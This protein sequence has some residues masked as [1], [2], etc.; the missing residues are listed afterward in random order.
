M[1]TPSLLSLVMRMRRSTLLRTSS[2][3]STISL[4]TSYGLAPRQVV[5]TVMRGR[6]NGG[7]ELDGHMIIEAN[8]AKQG[9][10]EDAHRDAD[11]LADRKLDEAH[12]AFPLE[13]LGSSKRTTDGCRPQLGGW[14]LRHLARPAYTRDRTPGKPRGIAMARHR[15]FF[16]CGLLCVLLLL[17]STA[18][19]AQQGR[20]ALV[21]V[22]P[23]LQKAIATPVTFVGTVEPRRRSLVASEL[24]G[25]RGAGVRRRRAAGRRRRAAGAAAPGAAADRPAR[26]AGLGRARSA[27]AGSS[28]KTAPGPRSC[29]RPRRWCKKPKPSWKTPG[30]SSTASSASTSAG[31]AAQ[32]AR[33][34][35]ETAAPRGRAAPRARQGALRAAAARGRAPSS[36]RKPKPSTM[37][38]RQQVAR[39]AYD[40]KRTRDHLRLLPASW[41]ASTPKS[42]S[43]CGK[44]RRWRS[45]ST[46]ARRT[47]RFLFPS[48]TC[49]PWKWAPP[50]PCSSTPFPAPRGPGG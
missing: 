33:E 15:G 40:L 49:P 34:E 32:K 12:A 45:S 9:D 41:C 27:S 36:W 2:C 20:P 28:S 4:S 10:E 47:S 23:V 35:A 42:A 5:S 17:G 50:L 29:A 14:R 46:L 31:I 22:A 8:D 1:P 43:G 21:E 39:L 19:H 24:G 48:A 38:P 26:A 30:A 11:G 44:A 16:F 13:A 7:G 6:S 3:S 18:L 37:P 25:H